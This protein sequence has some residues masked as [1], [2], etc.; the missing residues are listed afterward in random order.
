MKNI[1]DIY[2][3]NEQRLRPHQVYNGILADM[4]DTLDSGDKEAELIEQSYKEKLIH[5]I[6][7]AGRMSKNDEHILRD[8]F[9]DIEKQSKHDHVICQIPKVLKDRLIV[10][11][12]RKLTNADFDGLPDDVREYSFQVNLEYVSIEN[13]ESRINLLRLNAKD[14]PGKY[15]H[16]KN[17]DVIVLGNALIIRHNEV[18]Y[19]L[20]DNTWR[21]VIRFTD[22]DSRYNKWSR[23]LIGR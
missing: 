4:D 16:G 8:I 20:I 2:N 18:L 21:M 22:Y 11:S 23:P 6:T 12:K 9:N 19:I 15:V 5:I 17:V 1:Y 3:V 14:K 10:C 7:A 13:D